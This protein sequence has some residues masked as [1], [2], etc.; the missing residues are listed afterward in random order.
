VTIFDIDI[1]NYRSRDLLNLSLR[2]TFVSLFSRTRTLTKALRASLFPAASAS[3]LSLKQDPSQSR[4]LSLMAPLANGTV[5][6]STKM[7][8]KVVRLPLG[9]CELVLVNICPLMSVIMHRSSSVLVP[10]GTRPLSTSL[11]PTST[12]SSSKASWQTVLRLV[13]SSLRQLKVHLRSTL[14]QCHLFSFPYAPTSREL[15]WFSRRD[16]GSRTDG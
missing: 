12:P 8:S 11:A 6:G 1:C 2:S 15:P 3:V 7:H 13:A 5:P 10:L 16:Y 4:N 14:S 9:M